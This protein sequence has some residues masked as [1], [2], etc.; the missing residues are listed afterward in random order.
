M[1]LLLTSYGITNSSI[2]NALTELIGKQPS[3]SKIAFIPSGDNTKRGDKSWMVG[4]IN[5]FIE[6]GYYVDLIELTAL[7]P[8]AIK[9]AFEDVDAIVVGGGNCFYLSYW[10]QKK[11]IF[12]FLPQLL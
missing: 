11:G 4:H 10:M 6:A 5:K 2:A 1:K 8:D 7:E 12:D 3:E 9:S